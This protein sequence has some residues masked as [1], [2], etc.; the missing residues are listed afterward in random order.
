MYTDLPVTTRLYVEDMDSFAKMRAINPD[1][2]LHLLQPSG[3]LDVSEDVVQRVIE[4]ILHEPVHK[5]D[6]RGEYNDLYSSNLLINGV[7]RSAAFLLKGNGLRAKTMEIRHCGKNGDQLLRLFDSPAELFVVQFVGNVSEAVIKDAEGKTEHLRARGKQACYCIIN[8]LDTAR[9]LY[10]YGQISPTAA[11]KAEVAYQDTGED[12][13]QKLMDMSSR[14]AAG[15]C[16][17]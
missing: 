1:I 9:L 2:G 17:P 3:Y 8:G 13:D 14:S 7:R 10:A 4:A 12:A 16:N 11:A 15:S 5:E 6:L